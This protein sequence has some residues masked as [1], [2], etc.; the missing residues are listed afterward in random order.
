MTN[1]CLRGVVGLAL[2]ATGLAL[3]GGASAAIVS[4]QN[5]SPIVVPLPASGT[6]GNA[7]L[8]PS[9]IAVAGITD[10]TDVNVTLFDLSHV[11]SADLEIVVEGPT[12]K[13]VALLVD[14]GAGDSW[15]DDDVTY[16]DGAAAIVVGTPGTYV[17]TGPGGSCD[18]SECS[19]SGN[20][21]SVFNGVDPNGSWKLYIRDDSFG[22]IGDVG[23]GWRLT[24]TANTLSV[25]EPA[26][27][28]SL[29]LGLAG[30]GWARRRSIRGRVPTRA[31]S[32]R[33]GARDGPSDTVPR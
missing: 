29:G 17:P 26:T 7:S 24:F 15:T 12:G 4:F 31:R 5:N 22:D 8:F 30:L 18:L 21:L 2:M 19:E 27:L 1:R 23:N 3:G 6:F 16:S 28:A 10:V 9:T 11:S 20:L 32:C 25:P 14:F 33:P 13:R